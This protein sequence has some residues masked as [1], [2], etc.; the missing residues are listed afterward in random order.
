MRRRKGQRS[1]W[2]CMEKH[3]VLKLCAISGKR[4]PRAWKRRSLKLIAPQSGQCCTN[5]HELDSAW[6]PR[7]N[8]R[9]SMKKKFYDSPRIV[10]GF[11]TESLL[12]K[13]EKS[14]D[15]S[16]STGKCDTSIK[17]PYSTS[18]E[19]HGMEKHFVLFWMT[20]IVDSYGDNTL[21]PP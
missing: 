19:C 5:Y 8:R 3:F 15:S 14:L 4:S 13:R 9:C 20:K 11:R 18:L 21:G 7:L 1:P 10:D 12:E 17:T 2:A 6:D 16:T